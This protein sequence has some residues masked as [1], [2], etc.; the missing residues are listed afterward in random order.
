MKKRIALILTII[1]GLGISLASIYFM[2]YKKDNRLNSLL[3]GLISIDFKEKSNTINLNSN[4][5]MIDDMGLENTNP[6]EFTI[7]NT[8]K[9]PINLEIKLDIIHMNVLVVIIYFPK[10]INSCMI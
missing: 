4:V 10:K 8:S 5:P 6:Y 2:Y 9:V 3:N 1:L 7:T